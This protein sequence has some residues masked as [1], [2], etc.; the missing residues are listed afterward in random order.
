MD[1]LLT[2]HLEAVFS[3]SIYTKRMGRRI[4]LLVG[5]LC[6]EALPD[7]ILRQTTMLS[8]LVVLQDLFDALMEPVNAVA[9]GSW[10]PAQDRPDTYPDLAPVFAQIEETRRQIAECDTVNYAQLL[11]WIMARGRERKLL[12]KGRGTR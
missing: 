3:E 12:R 4:L 10:R 8:R 5:A 9:R 11:A 6:E 2:E 7:E 1:E